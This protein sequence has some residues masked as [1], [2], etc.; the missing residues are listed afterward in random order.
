MVV[1]KQKGS[2]GH[3]ASQRDAETEIMVVKRQKGSGGH[4][5]SQ[6]DAETEIMRDRETER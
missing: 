4:R 1:K 5:A 6:R 2:G 3:R